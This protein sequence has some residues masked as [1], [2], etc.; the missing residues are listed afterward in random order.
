MSYGTRTSAIVVTCALFLVGC[1]KSG[2]HTPSATSAKGSLAQVPSLKPTVTVSPTPTPYVVK[3]QV[4]LGNQPPSAA[5]PATD[6]KAPCPYVSTADAQQAQGNHIYLTTVTKQ[7]PPWCRFYFYSSPFNAVL[8]IAPTVFAT[9]LEAHNA[10][11]LTAQASTQA[12]SISSYPNFAP[13]VDL[14]SFRTAMFAPDNGLDWACAFVKGTTMVLIRTQ[15]K[16][17]SQDAR[18]IA[19]LIVNKF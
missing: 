18:N 2:D 5:I 17:T 7:T 16:D 13:G 15:Q 14:I 1:T 12:S 6:L 11:V 3:T 19:A 8:E 4:P 9:P 10:L